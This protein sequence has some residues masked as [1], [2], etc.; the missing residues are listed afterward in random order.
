RWPG[1]Y[2]IL[3]TDV[4]GA[5]LDYA[6]SRG[7]P[8]VRGNFLE[9]DFE[10]SNKPTPGPSQEGIG[11]RSFVPL[12]GGA[13]G[14]FGG[15]E[16]FDAV[17]FWAVI[18]HLAEPKRFLQKAHA[19]L[20][21]EGLCFVLVPNLSSLAVRLLGAKYRHVYPQHLN[22]FTERTLRQFAEPHFT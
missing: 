8:V 6:E 20:R 5:P 4:S 3:G 18:E 10:G 16:K 12:Q 15:V 17:T 9:L 22:Y 21:P 1:D 19:L 2:E 14:G 7:V 11:V 13:S